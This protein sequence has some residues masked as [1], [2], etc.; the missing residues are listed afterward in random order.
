ML[1]RC[2]GA[3]SALPCLLQQSTSVTDALADYYQHASEGDLVKSHNAFAVFSS[4]GK[5]VGNLTAFRPGEGYFFQRLAA[6]DV[7]VHFY[8]TNADNAPKRVLSS[9]APLDNEP[10]SNQKAATNMTMIAKVEGEGLSAYIGSELVGVATKNDSLYFL[11]IQSDK[12]GVLRFENADG[13]TLVPVRD[14]R[15]SAIRYQADAHAG[16]LKVPVLLHPAEDS[17]AYKVIENGHVIIIRNGERYD[18]TGVK[19]AE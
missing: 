10:F 5:W 19:L 8:N 11:T 3:W 1:L 16:T 15:I 17:C 4:S 12:T 6:G 18:V 13:Q 14:N 2:N 9:A 7:D